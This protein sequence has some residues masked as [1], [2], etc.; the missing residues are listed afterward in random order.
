[1]KVFTTAIQEI[2]MFQRSEDLEASLVNKKKE[3][4]SSG[5]GGKGLK[6]TL[7]EKIREIR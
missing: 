4:R 6:G 1:M 7:W 3:D 2:V 5:P